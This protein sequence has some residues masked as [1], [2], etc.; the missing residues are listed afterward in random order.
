MEN[1]NIL[2]K[3]HR[4]YKLILMLFQAAFFAILIIGVFVIKA[5]G[6]DTYDLLKKEYVKHLEEKTNLK[7]IFEERDGF[8]SFEEGYKVIIE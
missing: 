8:S 5:I 2:V 6:G 4:D 7:D 1:E 3:K